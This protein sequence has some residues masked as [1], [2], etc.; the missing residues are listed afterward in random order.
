MLKPRS[1]AGAIGI[2]KIENQDQMW[3]TLHELG[4]QQPCSPPERFAG[5]A[6]FHIDSTVYEQELRFAI[7]SGCG[8]PPMEVAHGGGVL[9]SERILG[10]HRRA[11]FLETSARVE[12]A[13]GK[14]PYVV[15]SPREDY[16]WLLVP[17]AR[18]N[19]RIPAAIRNLRS[20]GA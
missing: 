10:T 6:V 4:D 7:A 8:R 20:L 14:T 3:R 13:G 16:G 18:R 1:S 19:G 12:V 2:R 15:P 9:H 17:L 11:C 5:G